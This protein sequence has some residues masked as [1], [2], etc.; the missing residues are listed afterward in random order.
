[1]ENVELHYEYYYLKIVEGH[2]MQLF[3]LLTIPQK[4]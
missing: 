2:R 4:E 3:K 1:M